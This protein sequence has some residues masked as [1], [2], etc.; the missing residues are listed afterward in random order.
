[1]DSLERVRKTIEFQKPDRYPVMHAVLPAAWIKY[2]DLLYSLIKEYPT[3]IS[4]NNLLLKSTGSSAGYISNF[5]LM[6][7]YMLEDDFIFAEPRTFQFGKVCQT[8][9]QS[10]EWGCIWE[11][12]D[13]GIVGQII[14]HPLNKI[15]FN[16]NS[17]NYLRSIYNFPDPDALWRY[18]IPSLEQMQKVSNL[19]YFLVYIGNMFEL[20]QWLFGYEKLLIYFYEKPDLINK[21]IDLIVDYN[22]RTFKNFLNY[23]IHGVVMHDDWGTQ[24]ALMISPEMWRKFFKPGYKKIIAKAKEHGLHFHF[25][26]DGNTMEIV[27]DLI[28]IGVDVLNPQFSAMNLGKLSSICRGKICIR[29]DIDRQ[30]ILPFASVPEVENYI[31]MIIELFGTKAGGLILS[32]EI[33]SDA[34]LENVEKMYD[35]FEKYGQLEGSKK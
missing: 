32:G 25:H 19:K 20:M 17:I 10:D 22:I 5:E 33:N 23:N 16:E 27:E 11:K 8:G 6:Q 31:K 1:M 13:P 34:N 29:T 15:S 7:K 12:K 18:D 9:C 26:T 35:S 28:E 14:C 30:Y 4:E 2:G 3:Y 21:L 24:Q